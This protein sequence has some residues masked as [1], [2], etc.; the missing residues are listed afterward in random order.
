VGIVV[1]IIKREDVLAPVWKL[2]LTQSEQDFGKKG[3]SSPWTKF[4]GH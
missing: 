2:W 1:R 3:Q 4:K